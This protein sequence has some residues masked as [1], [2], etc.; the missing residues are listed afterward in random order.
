MNFH[1]AV[2]VNEHRVDSRGIQN[3]VIFQKA[4]ELFVE[5]WKKMESKFYNN[6]NLILIINKMYIKKK[7][8]KIN[9]KYNKINNIIKQL[10]RANC[11]YVNLIISLI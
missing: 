8:I 3:S 10:K 5:I 6:F 1:H 9:L 11:L 7:T 2:K 4:S